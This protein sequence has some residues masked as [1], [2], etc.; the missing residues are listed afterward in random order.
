MVSEQLLALLIRKGIAMIS[1]M[2]GQ[3]ITEDVQNEDDPWKKFIVQIQN[4]IAELDKRLLVR[5]L[6]KAREAKRAKTGQ[7]EGRKPFGYNPGEDETIKRIKQLYR[8]KPGEERLSC[9]RIAKVL[10]KEERPTR[11]G[12]PW[13]G[14]QVQQILKRLKVAK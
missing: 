11:Q 8:K 1:A 14:P 2:T 12:G 10:N 4:N 9:H 3:N 5:K 6:R 7:C 13:Q